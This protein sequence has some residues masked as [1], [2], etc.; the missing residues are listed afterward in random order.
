MRIGCL[1]DLSSNGTFLNGERV[2]RGRAEPLSDGDRISLVLSVAPLAEQAFIFQTGDPRLQDGEV[3]PEWAEEPQQQAAAGAGAPAAGAAGPER[4][5]HSGPLRPGS[6]GAPAGPAPAAAPA[7]GAAARHLARGV[8]N[9]Y[10]TPQTITLDDLQCQICLSVLRDC[11]ALEPC[12]HNYCAACLSH[13]LAALLTSGQPLACPLRCAPPERV[14]VNSAV[15]QLLADG[16]RPLLQRLRQ[17][18]QMLSL[19]LPS[20]GAA[21]PLPS[22]LEPLPEGF[23]SGGSA[24]GSLPLGG[25][26]VHS[27]PGS[28]QPGGLPSRQLSMAS[29]RQEREAAAAAAAAAAVAAV[30]PEQR[31]GPLPSG[32]LGEKAAADEQA[33]S[34]FGARPAAS[35]EHAQSAPPTPAAAAAAAAAATG[36]AA[37][38][39]SAA[40]SPRPSSPQYRHV[41]LGPTA[42]SASG[43]SLASP[44][45]S[46]FESVSSRLSTFS[47]TRSGELGSGLVAEGALALP[48][49]PTMPAARPHAAG[50][51]PR[52]SGQAPSHAGASALPGAPTVLAAQPLGLAA[53]QAQS[54]SQDRTDTATTGSQDQ[55]GAAPAAGSQGTAAAAPAAAVQPLRL[56]AAPTGGSGAGSDASLAAAAAVVAAAAAVAGP[57]EA[58]GELEQ[59]ASAPMPMHPLCP[60]HDEALPLDTASLKS[61]QLTHGLESL[62]QAEGEEAAMAHLESLARLAWSDEAARGKL[63]ELRAVQAVLASMRQHLDSDGVQCNGCLALMAL[64]RGEGAASDA[65][66]LTLADSG[67]VQVIAEGMTA[68]LGAPMVQLSA[69]LCLVPLALE[70]TYLQVTV[71]RSCLPS[72]LA[73]MHAHG[74]EP[75]VVGKALI[76]LGVLGQGEEEAHE[77]IRQTI[78]ERTRFPAICAAVL[79]DLGATNEDV[80]WS[81]L[82]ALAVIARDSS[83]RYVCHLLSLASAGVL[84]ALEQAMA[85]YRRAVDAQGAEPD[86]MI[87]RAGDYLISV[88]H[89]ARKLLWLRRTRQLTRLAAAGLVALLAVRWVRRRAGPRPSPGAARHG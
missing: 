45:P 89:T 63:G 68:H 65:N 36:A 14:V 4:R 16:G 87:L 88:L 44:P 86:E 20:G 5:P 43:S 58:S 54:G 50:S 15:R 70:N 56:P 34:S 12:G 76:M 67:G 62:Q 42:R 11:V 75:E 30:L 77:V 40:S 61:R 81:V 22:G 19:P 59:G 64:V 72:I 85:A 10:S 69:L 46:P 18:S 51:G 2:G 78:M 49:A 28:L 27:A 37:T 13:H 29:E 33:S 32:I 41:V 71:A 79:R 6:A 60:L 39:S 31:P 53:A 47:S 48:G 9:Q 1:Q 26:G 80:L 83:R 7:G 66:R 73:A 3:P 74:G 21:A 25:H 84:P 8:T 57:G 17:Q 24:G 23:T 82:F 52:G 38:S 35:S 55:G